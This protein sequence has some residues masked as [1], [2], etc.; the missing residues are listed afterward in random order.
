MTGEAL[1]NLYPLIYN[2]L[3]SQIT[4]EET[5]R[6]G[7]VWG[8][9]TYA[10]GQRHA[11]QWGG[12]TIS[13]YQG[14]ASTLRGGLS[15]GLSG[16]P[17]WSHDIGGFHL[18]PT[19]RPAPDLYIRWA[20]F[21]AFS[22]L[23][24][25]HGIAT[26]LPWDYD[27][28]ALQI[29]RD[30]IRLRYRLLPYIYSYAHTAART[31]LPLMRAMVLEFP[32]DPVCHHLDL[33]Y[34][35]GREFLVAPIY[36]RSGRRPVYFPA[37][38]WV[39]FWTHEVI[40]GPQMGRVEAP[41]E[42]LPLYV[43]AN[44]LIPTVEPASFIDDAPFRPVVFDAYLFDRGQFEL[45]DVDGLTEVVAS[46]EDS[47]LNLQITGAKQQVELRLLP[48]PPA[49]SINEVQLNDRWLP[50]IDQ[51]P[52]GPTT[53]AGWTVDDTGTVHIKT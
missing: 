32:H 18:Q 27:E 34:M 4:A 8:R 42:I 52:I 15:I 12:D 7:L 41:L 19:H 44:A 2:D 49:F 50:R 35:F 33:Q 17:F 47:R 31:S 39:D 30:Y 53:P 26:R 5:D 40:E 48:L 24:R 28:P 20:Q 46:L 21:G 37:G 36:N 29:V 23:A 6:A 14:L 25:L 9:S 38:R 45:Y 10:G 43:R 3:V 11:A 16:H 22:P 51:P 13:T 1:H